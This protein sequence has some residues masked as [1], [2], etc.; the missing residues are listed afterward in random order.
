[1]VSVHKDAPP[2]HRPGAYCT[3]PRCLSWRGSV[4]VSA[5]AKN[6]TASHDG[7]SRKAMP[8][9]PKAEHDAALS[10]EYFEEVAPSSRGAPADVRGAV[11]QA[12]THLPADVQGT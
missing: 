7:W 2:L 5:Y 12:G 11:D 10:D 9:A 4:S 3:D 1:M 6:K 8:E